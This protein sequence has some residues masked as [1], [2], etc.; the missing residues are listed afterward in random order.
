MNILRGNFA[1]AA[2]LPSDDQIDQYLLIEQTRLARADAVIVCGNS[3]AYTELSY[4]AA[5]LY[6]RALSPKIV[7]SG[8][9]KHGAQISEAEIIR[10]RL[11]D[12]DVP[13][14][15]IKVEEHASNTP[16]N[17]R[18]SREILEAEATRPL[19][20]AILVGS[21]V[22]GR[23]FLMTAAKEWPDLFVMAANV[24]PFP[25]PV[26]HWPV[27]PERSIIENEYEKIHRYLAKGDILEIDIN[28]INRRALDMAIQQDLSI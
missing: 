13:S 6:Y 28:N 3:H 7:V 8:G 11:M 27:Q 17:I 5:A 4:M 10:A 16:E 2:T 18:F 12:F 24:N 23:R 9:R 20:S 19:H 21:V 14:H 22:A 15:V 25:F 1:A 26:H